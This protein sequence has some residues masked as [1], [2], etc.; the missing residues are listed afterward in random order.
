MTSG[1]AWIIGAYEQMERLGLVA[2][3]HLGVHGYHLKDYHPFLLDEVAH[4][5]PELTMVFE[6]M[7]GWHFLRDAVAVA[8]N[9]RSEDGSPIYAGIASVLDRQRIPEW[10]LGPEGVSDLAW[11]IG[12]D[13]L[14][15]GTDFPYSTRENIAADLAILR[16]MGL[17]PAAKEG[18]L[19][20][21]LR[22]LLGLPGAR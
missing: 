8:A 3:F 13:H 22:A 5:F 20:E 6:H 1:C 9:H 12:A 7:G 10:Y 19:G 2:D 17:S 21:N 11:Q 14:I 18:I 15:Y 16:G 4:R